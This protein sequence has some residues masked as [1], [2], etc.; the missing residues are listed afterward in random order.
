MVFPR[1][2]ASEHTPHV[3]RHAVSSGIKELD[4][5]LGT[6]LESGTSTMLMGPA[7]VGK[8]TIAIRY[9]VA[10]A[11]RG[12]RSAIFTFDETLANLLS[13]ARG[14]GMGN[15]ETLAESG[16]IVLQQVDPTELSPGE[17]VSRVRRLVSQGVK[18][19]VIDSL[20]GFLN[21]M[22]GENYMAMQ[23]HELLSYLNQQNVTTLL[24]MAQQGMVG[25]QIQSP[26]DVSYLADC[27]ILLRYFET[28]GEVKQAISVI[29]KRTGHHERTIRELVMRNGAISVG[30]PLTAFEGVLS[31]VPRFV[32]NLQEVESGGAA[33]QK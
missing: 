12:D 7:G 16:K 24:T 4:A 29:K 8:S 32:G 6:G 17:F 30:R 13:R 20:N 18:L 9:A 21:A 31:G 26:V 28:F 5:L 23:L 3:T 14:L 15:L 25:N 1:L 19:V 11:D 2:I 22:P 10:A 33:G 27:V